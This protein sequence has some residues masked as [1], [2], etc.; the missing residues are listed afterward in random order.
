MTGMPMEKSVTFAQS[1][2]DEIKDLRTDIL[3]LSLTHG[4]A[5]QVRIGDVIATLLLVVAVLK[6]KKA[7]M[8]VAVSSGKIG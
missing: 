7:Q 4:G 3:K 5:V 1:R 8:S 6:L 2:K